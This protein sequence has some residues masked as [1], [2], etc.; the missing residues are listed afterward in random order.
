MSD[1]MISIGTPVE[2]HSTA[3]RYYGGPATVIA[4]DP[5]PKC[6]KPYFVQRPE[7][8][9]LGKLEFWVSA[10]EF[11]VIRERES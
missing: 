9:G 7:R 4:V 1:D 5:D 3:K 6:S 2:L 10:G 11:E 8:V